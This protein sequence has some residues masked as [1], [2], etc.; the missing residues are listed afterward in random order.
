[1]NPYI[2]SALVL[3]VF[4]TIIFLAAQK[5]KNNSIV[6]SF[7]GPAFLLVAISS[8]LAVGD[9]G[10]R[11][12]VLTLMVA[13]WALRLFLYI[14]IRNWKKPED[15][16]YINFR[17]RW[18]TSYALLKAYLHVFMLQGLF[19]Y[20]VALPI[21]AT[22]A[23]D[24]Q[25]MKFINYAGVLLW[26]VGFVFESVGDAQLKAFKADK[27]NK[28]KLM[29]EKLWRYTRHPNYF[30]EAVMWWGVYLVSFSGD[31]VL[32]TLISPVL[33]TLL[34]RFVSGVPM[35]EKKYEGREDFAAYK[36][37]TSIFFPWFPKDVK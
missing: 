32:L 21:M 22:T 11:T 15:Y 3:W 37:Q 17:K 25:Q 2:V 26:I 31:K 33:M 13:L 8:L 29:T 20:I 23:S 34:L 18:G 6:D 10:V 36:R 5:L 7:W 19:A 30:G 4:F 27:N 14:T 16:R 1:M 9:F 35:L 24:M 12:F 28:G